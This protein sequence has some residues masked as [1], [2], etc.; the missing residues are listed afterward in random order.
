MLRGCPTE[1]RL[2]EKTGTRL[3]LYPSRRFAYTTR[4][5]RTLLHFREQ[6]VPSRITV[7]DGLERPAQCVR[8]NRRLVCRCINRT[9]RTPKPIS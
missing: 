4:T 2:V 3:N 1:S 9:I 5:G 7:R 6:D 8:A